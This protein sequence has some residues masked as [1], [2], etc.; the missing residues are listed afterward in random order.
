MQRGPRDAVS[1][2]KG[3]VL[4]T[5]SFR[6]EIDEQTSVLRGGALPGASAESFADEL[7][8]LHKL[9]ALKEMEK[10]LITEAL[11]RADGNQTIAAQLLGM[12]RKALNNR[13]NRMR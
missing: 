12:S 9:P 10:L 5:E 3:G 4:S 6:Q 13:L 8:L 11:K 7:S 2:H 1:R